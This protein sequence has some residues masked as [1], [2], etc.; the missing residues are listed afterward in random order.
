MKQDSQ[1]EQEKQKFQAVI[2]I[3]VVQKLEQLEIIIQN[4]I[5]GYVTLDGIG[6]EEF[7]AMTSDY[8]VKVNGERIPNKW[9]GK[10]DYNLDLFGESKSSSELKRDIKELENIIN[11]ASFENPLNMMDPNE[12]TNVKLQNLK[13]ELESLG[14]E[15]L[16]TTEVECPSCGDE[17]DDEEKLESHQ[18][19]NYHGKYE[20]DYDQADGGMPRNE[21][22]GQ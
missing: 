4:N 3:K 19:T 16:E 14:G 20:D 9:D 1:R 15:E 2:F 22:G 11:M 17:F 6:I 12:P 21:I 18:Y 5:E 8:E 7:G 13:D 10:H